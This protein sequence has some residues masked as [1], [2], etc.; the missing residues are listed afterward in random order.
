MPTSALPP[1][2]LVT[3]L[4]AAVAA[5]L[6][7][8]FVILRRMA[9]VSDALSHVALPGLGLA[10]LWHRDP[11]IGALVFLLVAVWIVYVLEHRTRL[12][13]ESIVGVLFTTAL[14][15]GALVTPSESLL[16]GLFG[17]IG[18][19]HPSDAWVALGGSALVVLT[20]LALF[21]PIARTTLA[22]DLARSEG[23]PVRLAEGAYLVLL[24]LTVAIG[25]K[26]IGTLLMGALI[27]LPAATA[28]NLSGDLR[29]M[30]GVSV[31]VGVLATAAGLALAALRH[32]PPGPPVVLTS[33]F[34][35]LVTLARARSGV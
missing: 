17:D 32:W 1:A 14:A 3:G 13:A 31:S 8:V 23:V 26:V 29:S 27:I 5:S 2:V 12:A 4:A 9:L 22:P 30:V 6:L 21:R 19:V 33:A 11:F 15:L 24:A 7:G 35:F 34:I 28:K 18:K 25:I 10:L 20:L 16:E